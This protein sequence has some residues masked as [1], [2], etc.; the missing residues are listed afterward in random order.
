[1]NV[2]HVALNANGQKQHALARMLQSFGQYIEVGWFP[3]WQRGNLGEFRKRLLA[4]AGQLSPNLVFMQLQTE[5][6][7]TAETMKNMPG[8]KLNWSGDVRAPLPRWYLDMAPYFNVTAF[9]NLED[10]ESVRK[11]GHRAEYLQI[12]FDETVYQPTGPRTESPPIVFLG[13]NYPNTFPLSGERF[14]MVRALNKRYGRLFGV[15]G[16]GWKGLPSYPMLNPADEAA[17]YRSCKVAINQNHFL[18]NRFSSDRI[19]RAMGSGACCLSQ[20][21]PDIE[22]EFADGQHLLAWDDQDGLHRAIDM[23]LADDQ[24]RASLAINGCQHVHLNHTWTARKKD[25]ERIMGA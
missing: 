22:L 21:F 1:M 5:G 15:F 18:R 20:R 25:I 7:V 6:I 12:G 17:L 8:F 23:L 2:L 3:Y 4:A 19:F 10:V 24:R 16:G 13:S 9:T 11:S 14:E